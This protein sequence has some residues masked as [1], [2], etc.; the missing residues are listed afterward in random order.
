MKIPLVGQAYAARSLAVAAQQ[1]IN[2]FPEYIEDPQDRAKNKAV[3]YG[4]PGRHLFKNS[5]KD[6]R[7]MFTAGGALF[8]VENRDLVVYNSD[9]S[10]FS[11]H[12]YTPT[13]DGN[14]VF[15]AA[16]GTQLLIVSDGFAWCDSGS[17]PQKCRFSVEYFDLEIDA[18]DN[19]KLTSV[20]FPFDASDV[21]KTLDIT[22]G[23]GFTVQTV[24][25][26]AVVSGVATCSAALGT[27]GSTDGT[28]IEYTGYVTAESGCFLDGYFIVQR[29]IAGP[30]DP[31]DLGRRYYIS[32]LLD[33]TKWNALD[34]GAKESYADNLRSIMADDEQLYLFGTDTIEVHQN[35]GNPNF[36]FE[37]IQGSA[38][39]FG[40]RSKYAQASLDGQVFFLR[41]DTRGQIAAYVLDGFRPKRISNHAVEADWQARGNASTAI[42]WT[43]SEEGHSF[44]VIN[45]STVAWAYDTVTGAWHQRMDW[46]NTTGQF[47]PYPIFH[48]VFIPEWG[49]SGKHI[50]AGYILDKK[51]YEQS[52][53][54]YDDDGADRGWLRA[55]PYQYAEGKRIFF[56][57]MDLEMET[58]TTPSTTIAP[59]VW[60]DYSDDR[61]H[62][63]VNVRTGELG[64][65]GEYSKR[66]FWN[67][68][69]QSRGRVFRFR[70]VGQSKVALIDCEVD[71]TVGTV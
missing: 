12:T 53:D 6:I 27:V 70:G 16:N 23:T 48:H 40:A 34:Y 59:V 15:F 68:N 35:T 3:L 2:L 47:T 36:P 11:R 7:G 17:G 43:Y 56:G 46:T 4:T 49:G 19:T 44:W 58:G 29:P 39:K 67:R 42:S 30:G 60:M 54:F 31:I 5:G 38:S 26:S 33:G 45:F 28:G 63:F 64:V 51:I 71:M 9:G 69:G 57:R 18:A 37:R 24:T 25:I 65:H 32:A 8:V 10:E 14:P 22:G 1:T 66:V 52:V 61:G 20:S 55:L 41:G 21:G 13:S 62:T 50:V